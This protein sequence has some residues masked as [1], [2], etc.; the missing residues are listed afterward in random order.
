[1]GPAGETDDPAASRRAGENRKP[2]VEALGRDGKAVR[3]GGGRIE[4][5]VRPRRRT[6]VGH[7]G[8]GEWAGGGELN[9]RGADAGTWRRRETG[10]DRRL[11]GGRR[12]ARRPGRDLQV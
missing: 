12:E 11:A 1:M 2:A 3:A 6:G 10:V 4:R 7:R 9:G 5:R 8:R